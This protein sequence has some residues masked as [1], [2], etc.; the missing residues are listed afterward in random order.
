MTNITLGKTWLKQMGN[1]ALAYNITLQYCMSLSRHALQ[2]LEIEAVT[3]IRVTNDYATNWQYGGEQWR[4]GVS[5]IFASALGL[6]PFKGFI[7]IYYLNYEKNSTKY[8]IKD[9]YWTTAEQPGNPYGP[10]AI[11]YKVR[12]NSVVSTLTAGPVGPGDKLGDYIN[13]ELIMRY[14]VL[15]NFQS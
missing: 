9:V 15:L 14:I 11:D 5:S 8:F 13:K 1:A 10:K 12:L 3:Q 4:L 7:N 6:N 2:S